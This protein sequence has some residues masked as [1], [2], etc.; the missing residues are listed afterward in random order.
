MAVKT[1]GIPF[2]GIGEFTA[3]FRNYFSGDNP[4][5]VGNVGMGVGDRRVWSIFTHFDPQP[6]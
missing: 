1:N 5:S 2:W 4:I 6:D 3:H